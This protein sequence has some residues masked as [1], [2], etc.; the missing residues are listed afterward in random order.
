MGETAQLQ[1]ASNHVVGAHAGYLA[2]VICSVSGVLP[3]KSAES[4]SG[5]AMVQL[6]QRP[7]QG[8]GRG[9]RGE[10]GGR[11]HRS[12]GR[13]SASRAPSPRG[14]HDC[15]A[16]RRGPK[17]LPSPGSHSAGKCVQHQMHRWR[18]TPRFTATRGHST[19]A[20]STPLPRFPPLTR[21]GHAE[22]VE[23]PPD[24]LLSPEVGVAA[25]GGRGAGGAGGTLEKSVRRHCCPAIST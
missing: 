22:Q 11:Q 21:S 7:A 18:P 13:G 3:W 17:N 12:S 9:R 10:G 5:P 23:A 4:A 2:A 6:S 25:E 14:H 15:P 24:A 1:A 19:P 16:S 8:P 20:Q